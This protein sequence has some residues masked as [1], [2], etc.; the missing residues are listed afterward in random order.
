MN[1]SW[2]L[3]VLVVLVIPIFANHPPN[4]NRPNYRDPFQFPPKYYSVKQ[5]SIALEG[6]VYSGSC[7][8]AAVLSRGSDRDVVRRGERFCGYKLSVIGKN[9]VVL[10]RGGIK[11]KIILD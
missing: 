8:S 2:V 5:C 9:F 6:I 10:E 7:R 3:Y 4:T 1:W 11:K